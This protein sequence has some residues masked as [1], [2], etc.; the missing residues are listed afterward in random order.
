[1]DHKHK[2]IL[3][4]RFHLHHQPPNMIIKMNDPRLLRLI[5]ISMVS[6]LIGIEI[7]NHPLMVPS[8]HYINMIAITSVHCLYHLLLLQQMDLRLWMQWF[9]PWQV[10]LFAEIQSV[11]DVGHIQLWSVALHLHLHVV[12]EICVVAD[13][14]IAR[15]L[16]N[17]KISHQ[18]APIP[19]FECLPNHLK[20]PVRTML[21]QQLKPAAVNIVPLPVQPPFLNRTDIGMMRYHNVLQ[22]QRNKFTGKSRKL[23]IQI[24]PTITSSIRHL[25]TRE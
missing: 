20:L 8:W 2:E 7:A 22:I 14:E 25:F 9:Q 10:V 23:N 19:V 11:D 13:V 12:V 17:R 21:P 3:V 24:D 1:M 4:S 18:S 5:H 15:H 16:L 6:I